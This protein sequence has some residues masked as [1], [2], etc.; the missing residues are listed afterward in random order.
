MFHSV[1]HSDRV[2]T[3][4]VTDDGAQ[5]FDFRFTGEQVDS[6]LVV[7]ADRAAENDPLALDNG[8]ALVVIVSGFSRKI[9]GM[10]R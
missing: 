1:V 6:A 7:R 3:P 10:H 9:D 8:I 2:V 4:R 5:I